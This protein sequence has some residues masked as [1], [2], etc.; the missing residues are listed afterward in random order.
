MSR[1][2]MGVRRAARRYGY[3]PFGLG[4]YLR[5]RVRG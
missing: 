2:Y 3:G 4:G 5:P 1:T